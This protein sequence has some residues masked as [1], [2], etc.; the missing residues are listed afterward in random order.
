VLLNYAL[1]VLTGL[2]LVGIFPRFGFTLLA[3]FAIAPLVYALS[4]EWSPKHRFL[5]GWVAGLIFWSLCNYWIHFVISVHGGLGQGLGTVGF[6]LFVLLRA[7]PMGLFAV[8]AG[9]AVQH[10]TAVIAVPAMWVAMERIPYLYDY[11]WLML[12]NAGIDM[13]V[14]MRLA[15]LTGVYGLSFVFAVLGTA[16]A[17]VALRRPRTWLIPAAIILPILVLPDLPAPGLPT[18]DAVSVQPS[19]EDRDNWTTTEAV[20]LGKQMEALTMTPVLQS[21][22]KPALLLWP[23]VPA[24]IYYYEDAWLREQVDAMV[25]TAGAP[26]LIGTVARNSKGQP[27]NS[28]TLIAPSGQKFD[29]YDKV[30]L[31]PFGEYI[32]WP[33][34]GIVDKISSEIGDFVPGDR[35][36]TFPLDG[37]Q[38][39]GA[40]ICYESAFPSHVRQFV[41]QGATVLANLSNDGYFGDSA[42]R[43]QHLFLVR[44]RAAENRR[45]ILRSTN[46]G[47]TAS[48]D[49]AGRIAR[50]LND[51]QVTSGRLLFSFNKDATLYT[52][53]GD[54]FAWTCTG[55]ALILLGLTQVPVYRKG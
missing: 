16:V 15:P 5:L 1:A 19:V 7:V 39:V 6:V 46:N 9:I 31:V 25:R 38:R 24:P 43:E 28:A 4:R 55:L 22:R 30:H 40:F 54:W 14:P 51:K 2:L 52:Q 50:T 41:A 53:Y 36:V 35:V 10:P 11:K 27:L 18:A 48:I 26:A 32:P 17:L 21:R 3:P 42:A 23:E 12:G 8:C 34:Q 20:A 45:W 47:I 37:G 49:P 33:F 13:P 44:M 29:H